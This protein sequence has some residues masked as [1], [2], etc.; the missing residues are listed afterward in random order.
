LEG[1][2]RFLVIRLSSLGDVLLTTKTIRT[3]RINQPRAKIDFLTYDD[4]AHLLR[5][6]NLPVD[7][8]I[9]VKKSDLRGLNKIF[10]LASSL[11]IN[12]YDYI[13]DL[14]SVL[15]SIL[16]SSLINPFR[17]LRVKKPFLRRCLLIIA[18]YKSLD[19]SSDHISNYYLKT[20]KPL[21]NNIVDDWT[22]NLPQENCSAFRTSTKLPDEYIVFAPFSPK[23]TKEWGCDNFIELGRSIHKINPD[24]FII[25]TGLR[26]DVVRGKEIR[27]GIGENTLCLA[28]ETDVLE[29]ACIIKG[30]FCVVSGDSGSAHLASALKIPSVVLFGPTTQE[31]GFSPLGER[32]KVVEIPLKCRPCSRHGSDRCPKR[33]FKCMEEITPEMVHKAINELTGGL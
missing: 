32:A 19:V 12:K 22:L 11:R 7:D 10:Q 13:I 15:K 24:L 6:T 30:A 16:L 23:K 2:R 17:V 1:E 5:A 9:G 25:I 20:I 28:G 8:V 27:N 29:L 14:H 31:L 33:H 3:L 18:K 26:S 4:Y 21:Q